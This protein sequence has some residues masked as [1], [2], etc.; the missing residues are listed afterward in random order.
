M[1]VVMT[2]EATEA[3]IEAVAERVRANGGE[4]FVSRGTVHTIVGLV[5]D[6]ARFRV[7]RLPA[8]AGR[9]SRDPHRQALQDGR[10]R[11]APGDDD[12]EGRD[13]AGRPRLVHDHRRAL[14]RGVRG[15]G[16]HRHAGRE[17]RRRHDPARRRLQAPDLAVLVP[18]AGGARP[19]D[20]RGVPAR[21]RAADRR[22]GRRR[23]AGRARRRDRRLHPRGDAQRAE[24]RA[25][26]GGR[27]DEQARHAE[28]RSGHD[29][30]G[31]AAGRRVHRAA[32]QLRDHPVRARDPD[33]RALDPQHARPRPGWRSP[34]TSRTCR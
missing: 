8:D 27:A 13:H 20:P 9:G 17:G 5:G 28:A 2:A 6:T 19:R 16:V 25:A 29:D 34:S 11:P 15:A 30:R 7:D 33:V 1:V 26:E 24:L 32:R 21:H 14:R 22:R 4:A 3:E 10:A 23:L 31:V 12:R 18:G